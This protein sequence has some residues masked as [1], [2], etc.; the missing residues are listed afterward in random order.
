MKKNDFDVVIIGGG[1]AGSVAGINLARAGLTT[2]IIERKTF[3][4]DTLCGE[5]LSYEV[6]KHLRELNLFEKFLALSPNVVKS[7]KFITRKDKIF[8]TTLP[9]TAYS[10]KRSVF[11]NFLLNEAREAGA[12]TL[13][14]AETTA[15]S[16]D[17]GI[18]SLQIK[19]AGE[20]KTITSGYVIGA[21]G[22][23][24]I[25]DKKLQRDFSGDRSGFNAIKF[26]INKE[27]LSE[28][29]DSV[30]YIF[31]GHNIYCGVNTVSK[32]EAV[33]CFLYKKSNLNETPSEK[34]KELQNEN[35]RFA[36]LFKDDLNIHKMDVYGAGNIYLGKREIIK[37]GIMMI[38][39]AAGMIAP[40]AGDGIGMAFQSARTAAGIMGKY[41]KNSDHETVYS[42]YR[43]EWKKLFSKRI[44]IANFI[45]NLILKNQPEKL[46]VVTRLLLPSFVLATRI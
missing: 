21:Y 28:I 1:P 35:R 31:S 12:F 8:N 37:D 15:V 20:N 2:A 41:I 33:V 36:R 34:F 19:T 14:P 44:F 13:Q 5:F 26:H 22:K 24:N 40:V 46:P 3:P 27:L 43:K 18:F 10:L 9:F 4:R 45:Q 32:D 38:G 30:I 39:D 7:F 23:S 11:D 25:L 42:L 16:R 29:D 6:S 17:D